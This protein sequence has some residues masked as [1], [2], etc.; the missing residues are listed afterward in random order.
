MRK[1]YH[2]DCVDALK[3]IESESVQLV[4]VDVPFGTQNVQRLQSKESF[5]SSSG[6][7][8]FGGKKYEHRV[9]SDISYSDVFDD[10]IND[11]IAPCMHEVKRVL[12][13]TGTLYL[14]C[15]WRYVHYVKVY[16]DGLF[17][18]ENFMNHVIW[19]F[20]YG[21]RGKRK[22]P[23]KHNDILVY[24]RE[25]NEQVFNWDDI[26]KIPYKAPGLQ[27]DPVRAAA[28]QVPTD[29]W[30]MTIVPTNSKERTGYPTQKPLKLVERVIRASSNPGDV[31]LDFCVGSGTTCVAAARLD[32]SF[33]GIDKSATSMSVMRDRF[34]TVGIE[35]V[36]WLDVQG[37]PV[38][39]SAFESLTATEVDE[40]AEVSDE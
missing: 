7:V 19:S 35:S 34:K 26:D 38:D 10:Y 13:R 27:K 18:R 3:L 5:A 17:G 28:G 16:L 4:Y 30:E 21:G 2:G 6:S 23:A 12:K 14:H 32:R 36:E 25:E 37:K 8:G 29:V 40:P 9:V 24:S 39:E 15:D 31:V 11:F 20:N 22:W 1:I 33:I